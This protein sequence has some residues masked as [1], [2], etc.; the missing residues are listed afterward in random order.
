MSRPYRLQAEDCFYHI[1]ARGNGKK[2]IFLSDKDRVRFFTYLSRAMEKFSFCLYAYVLMDN[3]YH[4]L[5]ETKHPNLSRI[6]HLINTSYSSYYNFVHKHVGHLLQGRFK[7][8][9]VDKDSYFLTLSAYIH[10]NPVRANIVLNP[11]DYKWSSYKAYIGK[12]NDPYI[13]IDKVKD[14]L[15][16]NIS[17]YPEFVKNYSGNKDTI[18]NKLY[19]GFILG[20]TKFIKDNLNTLKNQHCSYARETAYKNELERSVT[21]QDIINYINKLYADHPRRFI[22]SNRKIINKNRI[23]IYLIKRLTPLTTYEIGNMF[24]IG[25]S[26]VSKSTT[27]IEKDMIKNRH[28]ANTLYSISSNFEV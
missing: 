14:V 10:L 20:N 28:L 1:T 8:I 6:M 19:A 15:G 2:N 16:P 9:V 22:A 12:T 17:S 23:I 18:F 26:A 13:N 4:L 7:S 3:H 25:F 24:G 5:I 27:N 11:E 21:P